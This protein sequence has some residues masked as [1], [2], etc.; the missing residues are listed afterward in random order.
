[1]VRL[2]CRGGDQ[3]SQPHKGGRWA[4]AAT[5]GGGVMADL[6]DIAEVEERRWEM[7][8]V[9]AEAILALLPRAA[10]EPDQMRDRGL[11]AAVDALIGLDGV[12]QVGLSP[13]E[14]CRCQQRGRLHPQHAGH[15]D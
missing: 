4:S 8:R 1:M 9:L 2:A 13:V 11:A 6:R 10:G 12:E 14:P 5:S 7:V 3:P 15:V